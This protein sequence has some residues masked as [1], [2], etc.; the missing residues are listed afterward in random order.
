M[1]QTPSS[2]SFDRAASFY[3]DTRRLPDDI[4]ARITQTILDRVPPDAPILECGVGTGRIAAPLLQR[5]ANL[6]GV[7]LSI[8]MMHKLLE[9]VERA[10]LAQAD[11]SQLPFPNATFGTVLTVHVLHLVGPWR[12][13]LREFKR[14]LRPGGLY[15]NSHNYRPTDS[16]NVRIRAQWHALLE[17]RGQ[18]WRRP[19]TRDHDE[20][21]AELHALGAHIEEIAVGEWASTTTPRRELDQIAARTHSDG[22]GVS[23]E[24]LAETTT[25]LRTWAL[26]EYADLDTPIPVERR[27][28][29]DAVHF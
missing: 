18:G 1:I 7:D 12:E 21:A 3:D 14:V 29:F 5:G 16:P 6:F 23:D 22:W 4:S 19:G 2:L 26:A 28:T 15:L 8:E 13:A 25:E 9:K 10:R 17:A 20:L 11:V 24:A 27:F